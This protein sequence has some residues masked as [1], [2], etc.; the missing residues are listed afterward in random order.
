MKK[1]LF[2]YN[3]S[4]IDSIIDYS[5]LLLNR[6]FSQIID[7]YQQTPY[8][9][10]EDYQ[11]KTAS[12]ISESKISTKSKGKYGNYIEQYFYGYKPNN[13]SAADFDKIGVDVKVTPFKINKNGSISAKERLVLTI[14]DYMNEN[15]D[16]FYNTHLW[17]KCSKM[18]LLFYNGLL[19]DDVKNNTIEKIFLY[20]WFSEDMPVI[21][22]DYKNITNKIKQGKAHELSES[23]G[24]YLSVCTKGQSAKTSRQQPFSKVPAK[25]RA[26]SLKPR[27]MTYLLR[28][29]IFEQH[30]QESIAATVKNTKQS[31]TTI[32]T[33]RIMQY[34]GM[35]ATSLYK[36]F[37]I[38]P[39]AKG[40]NSTLIRK[41]IGLTGDIEKTQEFQKANMNL[42]VI[43]IKRNGMPKEDSPFKEYNFKELATNDNWEESQPYLE[44]CS[45]RFLFVT[46]K[47]NESGDFILDKIKFWGF[48]DRLIPEV[49][50]VWQETRDIINSGVKLTPKTKS[51]IKSVS[52]NF[53]TSTTNKF[54]FTKIHARNPYY[55]LSSGSFVGSG[56]LSDTDELPDGRRITKHSFWF[57]KRFVKE[58]LD[59]KWD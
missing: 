24:N 50:R 3:D 25:Q 36:K 51:K 43:R 59:G 47:E 54:V 35:P 17:K 34:K 16:D 18:L 37:N 55:E 26:W 33:N 39:K 53:P 46:F 38:N 6:K 21:L 27:Y 23:D 10:Y 30:E 15:L 29:K 9:T 42:R 5:Q 8:K 58:I 4:D 48:P 49:Q 57:P 45:K 13:N 22:E 40:K 44:I 20:E 32:I 31:F 56:K 28:N 7:D 19:Y 2:D 1:E 11:T 14:L 12:K 41:I 52:T